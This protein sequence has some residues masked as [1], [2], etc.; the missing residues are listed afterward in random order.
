MESKSLGAQLRTARMRKNLTQD[1]LHQVCDVSAS[2]ISRIERDLADPNLAVMLKICSALECDLN[3]AYRSP[4]LP[5]TDHPLMLRIL[6]ALERPRNNRTYAKLFGAVVALLADWQLIL[7][8]P[9]ARSSQETWD[10]YT[11]LPDLRR[12]IEEKG[13]IDWEF[14]RKF[15]PWSKGFFRN[16]AQQRLALVLN[17]C[18]FW[19]L[20]TAR[21][22]EKAH[23]QTQNFLRVST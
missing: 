4:R 7:R 13:Y 19:W 16:D 20:V 14:S 9:R 17:Q 12:C 18:S 6:A 8:H 5:G 15:I 10:C 2:H 1:E 11:L 21:P 3:V 22:K 23:W